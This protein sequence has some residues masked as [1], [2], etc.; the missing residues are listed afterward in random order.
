MSCGRHCTHILIKLSPFQHFCCI[1]SLIA[2]FGSIK[3]PIFAVFI[4]FN[5]CFSRFMFSC[6]QFVCTPNGK[7]AEPDYQGRAAKA[8]ERMGGNSFS[9]C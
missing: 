2:S 5:L 7:T 1:V 4:H 6:C 8:N 9:G 3:S